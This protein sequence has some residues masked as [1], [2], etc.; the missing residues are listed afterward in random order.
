MTAI[1]WQEAL[2]QKQK[3]S[4]EFDLINVKLAK[5]LRL[6]S[7]TKYKHLSTSLI[8]FYFSAL[9]GNNKSAI[10]MSFKF[11]HGLGTDKNC[12]NAVLFIH[13]LVEDLYIH[14]PPYQR[15]LL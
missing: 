1:E 10:A 11:M 13:P 14:N 8:D 5:C 7:Y 9:Q 12:S 3:L 6:E 4:E 15:Y 2:E